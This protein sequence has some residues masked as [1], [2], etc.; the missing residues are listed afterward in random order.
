MCAWS[1]AS[2]GRLWLKQAA[3]GVEEAAGG[4]GDGGYAP[5]SGSSAE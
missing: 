1:P 5:A 3:A 2:D 4:G